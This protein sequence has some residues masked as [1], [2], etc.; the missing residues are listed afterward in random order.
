MAI[1][2]FPPA[3]GFALAWLLVGAGAPVTIALGLAAAVCAV[4]TVFSQSMIYASLRPIRQWHQPAVPPNF[5]L[6]A[7]FS[8]AACLTVV[9]GGATVPAAIALTTGVAGLLGKLAYWRAIDRGTPVATLASATGLGFLGQVR[10]LELPHTEENYLLR[11]M[12]F[13]IAR[14]HARRLRAIAAVLGF[15]LP[16]LLLGGALVGGGAVAAGAAAIAT[17]AGVYVERWLFFAEATH[18]VTLYYGRAA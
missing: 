4:G 13:A 16:L 6:L 18:T 10:S 1:V 7:M 17:L 3:G 8:G 5:L 11:E 12:G 2:T 15:V 14:R 9:A